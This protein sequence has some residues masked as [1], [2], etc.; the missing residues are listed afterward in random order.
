VRLH[1]LGLDFDGDFAQRLR[2]PDSG[3]SPE[4]SAM[5]NDEHS[6]Q[7]AIYTLAGVIGAATL[8]LAATI[9]A[10]TLAFLSSQSAARTA[11]DAQ[12][13]QIGVAVLSADPSAPSPLGPR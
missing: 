10:A 11:F 1:V 8:T 3:G 5:A 7:T 2:A 6:G 9:G 4:R 12:M 13:V